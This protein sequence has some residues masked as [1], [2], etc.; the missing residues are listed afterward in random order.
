MILCKQLFLLLL[1]TNLLLS[2]NITGFIN[3]SSNGEPVPFSNII[4]QETY[5]DKI[6]KGTSS[7]INGYYIITNVDSGEYKINISTIGY[8]VYNN[9]ITINNNVRLDVALI[10]QA[11]NLDEV[12]IS[13]D[14]TR[15]N[16][17]VEVSRINI[18][19]EEIKM[20]PA[21]TT[22]SSSTFTF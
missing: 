18:S 21:R 1:A 8:K 5:S 15:F 2:Y 13:S 14:R 10:P 17:K 3:N 7:D 4:L 16:E 20:I 19:S 6:L 12:S 9:T 11:I 22:A